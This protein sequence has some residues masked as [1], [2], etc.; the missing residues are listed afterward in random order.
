LE[1]P[2]PGN[3][4]TA[5]A[6]FVDALKRRKSMGDEEEIVAARTDFWPMSGRP[7]LHFSPEQVIFRELDC[8]DCSDPRYVGIDVPTTFEGAKFGRLIK[9][10]A[11]GR[12]RRNSGDQREDHKLDI[13]LRRDSY[14]VLR[15][16][17]EDGQKIR[18]GRPAVELAISPGRPYP[19]NLVGALDYVDDSG[20][21][22]DQW[23]PN[24]STV[25]FCAAFPGGDYTQSLNY[26]VE[27]Y[28]FRGGFR[29]DIDPDIRH[30]GNGGGTPEVGGN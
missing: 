3:R 11:E 15:I 30:P 19:G 28:C 27:K 23:I 14:I 7:P 18:F 1:P 20:R 12:Y 17:D 25:I 26:K 29:A 21:I 24:C 22:H 4:G 8:S 10:I 16:A 13:C 6:A 9:A 2:A 5:A